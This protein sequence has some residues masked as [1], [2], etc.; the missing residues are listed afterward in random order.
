MTKY[1]FENPIKSDFFKISKMENMIFAKS[2]YIFFYISNL[3]DTAT[4]S[5]TNQT[6]KLLP[7][8]CARNVHYSSVVLS[9]SPELSTHS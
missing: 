1:T 4:S 7:L 2:Q 5:T 8:K 3:K 6:T 9:P